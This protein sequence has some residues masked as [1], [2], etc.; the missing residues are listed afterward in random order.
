MQ[1]NTEIIKEQR[2]VQN[3]CQYKEGNLDI[4][5]LNAHGFPSNRLNL[6][7]E[8]EVREILK[9]VHIATIMETGI[10]NDHQL[11]TCRDDMEIKQET[12]MLEIHNSKYQHLGSG[13]AIIMK[14]IK[15][16]ST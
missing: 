2:L 9:D 13:T 16:I 11:W 12:K 4:L 15:N 10:N 14:R 6:E 8:K 1:A 3:E 5:M 7:K